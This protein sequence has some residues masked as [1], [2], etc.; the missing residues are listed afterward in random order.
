MEIIRQPA[1][2]NF[3]Q[4]AGKAEPPV[5]T[6][7]QRRAIERDCRSRFWSQV[8]I[9]VMIAE[10]EFLKVW[11]T[12]EERKMIR[13]KQ[14]VWLKASMGSFDKFHDW[15]KK[16][17]LNMQTLIA[18]YAVQV[19]RQ[20]KREL[21][22][23]YVTFR[24]YF[25]KKGMKDL[26]FNTQVEFALVLIHLARDLFDGFFDTYKDRFGIDLRA[27]YL[28]ARIIDA[29]NN[30]DKFTDDVLKPGKHELHPCK[31][32]ASI[33]AYEE[34]CDKMLNED[35]LD[36]AGLRA[37]ELNHEDEFLSKLERENMGFHKL[38]EKYNIS[39]KP[40]KTG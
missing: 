19:S 8:V 9:P 25:E 14:G 1:R 27:E 39:E 11:D 34:L 30:F 17:E 15:L 26:D 24:Y 23:L 20:I 5:L 4:M 16:G 2:A 18:D 31:N 33:K 6:T 12:C 22:S 13:F 35:V 21:R 29:D 10:V 38:K 40:M 36:K 3:V 7:E 37:L 28:P 32:Y